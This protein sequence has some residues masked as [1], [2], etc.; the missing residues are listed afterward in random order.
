[1]KMHSKTRWGM[2]IGFSLASI[3][4]LGILQSKAELN[5]PS[6][7]TSVEA[8]GP[9]ASGDATNK[10]GVV[11]VTLPSTNTGSQFAQ[12]VPVYNPTASAI[13]AGTV[14]VSSNVAGGVAYINAGAATNDLTT[15]CGVAA[16]SIAATSRGWMIPRGGGYAVV[17]ATGIVTIGQ[18][19]VTTAA[20]AGYATGVTAPT[21]GADFGVAISSNQTQAGGVVLAILH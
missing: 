5:A 13:A 4:V 2:M 12:W 14:L 18:V 1:M 19:L 7:F 3:L 16:E 15:V 20:A 10:G 11:Y 21:T 8:S 17:K 6:A 9:F